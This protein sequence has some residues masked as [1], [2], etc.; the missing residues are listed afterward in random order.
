MP[1]DIHLGK[2]VRVFAEGKTPLATERNLPGAPRPHAGFD[3]AGE[4]D[5]RDDRLGAFNQLFRWGTRL[6]ALQT[7]DLGCFT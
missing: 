7:R 1:A 5:G 3:Y 4:D 6:Q 2:H